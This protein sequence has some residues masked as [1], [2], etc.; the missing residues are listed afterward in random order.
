MW[1]LCTTVFVYW[2]FDGRNLQHSHLLLAQI[3]TA[4]PLQL[5]A[6]H[7]VQQRTVDCFDNPHVLVNRLKGTFVGRSAFFPLVEV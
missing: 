5:I 4:K 1:L 3:L 7:E 6:K 2:A